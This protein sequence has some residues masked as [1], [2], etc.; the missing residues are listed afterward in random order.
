MIKNSTNIEYIDSTNLTEDGGV[1]KKIITKGNGKKPNDRDEVI[2]H[3]QGFLEDGTLFDTSYGR[4]DG[5]KFIIGVG[6]VIKG[7]DIG[8]MQMEVGERSHLIVSPNYGY[9][10]IGNLPKIPPNA[11]LKFEIELLSAQER[12]PTKWMMND[13]EK[14]KIAIKLK[15]DGNNWFRDK[16]YKEAEGFYR[17]AISHL[18]SIQNSNA[19]VKTLK[20][21]IL[22]NVAIVCNKSQLWAECVRAWTQSL[23]IDS[24]NPKALYNRGIAYRHLKHYEE[25]LNDLKNAVKRN[26]NDKAIRN[27]LE[28]CREE[29]KVYDKNQ[30]NVFQKF[31]KEGV[32]EEKSKS[33]SIKTELPPYNSSN[34]KWFFDIK[35]GEQEPQR[36]IFELFKDQVPLTVENFRW[37]CTGEKSTESQK[38]HFKDSILH[39]I[40]PKFMAQGGDFTNFNGTGGHSIYGKNFNDEGVWLPHLTG[41]LLSMANRGPNTNS[42]QFFITFV[43]AH[44]LDGKHTVF[45]RVIKGKSVLIELENVK[46]AENDKP[47]TDVKVIDWGEVIEDILETDLELNENIEK[48]SKETTDKS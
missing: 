11:I 3:Y 5:F 14:T 20:K 8:I 46:T 39:R 25:S 38:L 26:P 18:D 12:R 32:Y 30:Q 40:I 21:T 33:S 17:E 35:I 13:E 41:G 43:K 15:E 34:P 36:I 9:G 48:D 1:I 28:L 10:K 37:L 16:S 27:E 6:H 22:V 19:E 45:G 31:F 29:K 4:D 44:W 47:I 7:W 2:V 24:E 23:S 42:S